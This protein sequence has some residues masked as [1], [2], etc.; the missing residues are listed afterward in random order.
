MNKEDVNIAAEL[1]LVALIL[2]MGVASVIN[3]DSIRLH[4]DIFEWSVNKT[5]LSPTIQHQMDDKEKEIKNEQIFA[6]VFI[7]WGVMWLLRI[8]FKPNKKKSSNS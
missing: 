6:I 8:R 1:G 3:A 7:V 2:S 5:S 4:L